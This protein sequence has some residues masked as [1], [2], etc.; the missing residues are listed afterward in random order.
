MA[1]SDFSHIL[2]PHTL[3]PTP[4][5]KQLPSLRSL[6][7]SLFVSLIIQTVGSASLLAYRK[8]KETV[9]PTM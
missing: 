7:L 3:T 6:Q 1:E 4:I 2:Y 5:P 8:I 9:Q